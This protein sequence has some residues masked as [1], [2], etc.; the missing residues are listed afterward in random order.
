MVGRDIGTVVF[1]EAPLKIFLDASVE[2][3]AMRRFKEI[4]ERN[5]ECSYQGILESMRK[6]DF[7]DSTRKIAP[8]VPASDAI[9]INTDGLSIDTVLAKVLQLAQ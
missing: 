1:P 3:R 6:R 9:I 2:E 7:I 5:E 4:T 8:L